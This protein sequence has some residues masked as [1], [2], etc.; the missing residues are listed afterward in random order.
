MSIWTHINAS[1]RYDLNGRKENLPD[2]NNTDIPTGSEGKLR[3]K[4]VKVKNNG[5]NVANVIIWGDLRDFTDQ[6]VILNYFNGLVD[7]F[8]IRS[9]ILEIHIESR[10]R[11]VY[12]YVDNYFI[13]EFRLH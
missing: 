12:T 4:I 13:E 11:I 5:S 2:F 6:T 9:A 7:G 3:Y 8:N 10:R 1:I